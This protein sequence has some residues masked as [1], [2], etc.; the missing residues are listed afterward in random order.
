VNVSHHLI[1]TVSVA[2]VATTNAKG[3]ATYGAPVA[4]PARVWQQS[5]VVENAQGEQVK[6]SHIVHT[7]HQVLPND[8]VWIPGAST[9]DASAAL[10][11]VTI[12]AH[13]SIRG[14]VVLYEVTLG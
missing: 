9:S 14:D 11:P 6:T 13:Q 8:R 10:T 4:V 5:G 1:Q 3:V 2:S 12:V 7:E